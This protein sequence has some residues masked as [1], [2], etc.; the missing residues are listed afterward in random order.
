MENFMTYKIV[1]LIH[2]RWVITQ[3]TD[4]WAWAAAN[5]RHVYDIEKS[6]HRMPELQG[7]PRLTG[8]MGPMFDGFQNG[9]AVIRYEDRETNDLLS[10]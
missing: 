8:L 6:P 7:Q 3:P 4:V 1:Q 2:G 9:E 5:D 10:T